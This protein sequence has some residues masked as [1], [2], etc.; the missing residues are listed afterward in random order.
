M[1]PSQLFLEFIKFLFLLS[2]FGSLLEAH[3]GITE[4][5]AQIGNCFLLLGENFGCLRNI[6]KARII[7]IRE[8]R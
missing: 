5:D 4:D 3:S 6:I 2:G 1:R 7:L 8:L